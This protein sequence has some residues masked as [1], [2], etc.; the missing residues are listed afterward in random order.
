M[1][2]WLL[3]NDISIDFVIIIDLYYVQTSIWSMY[4][5]FGF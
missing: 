5:N 1:I 2:N 4:E 3:A